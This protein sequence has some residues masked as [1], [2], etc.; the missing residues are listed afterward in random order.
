[1]YITIK[2]KLCNR[3]MLSFLLS[4]IIL[5]VFF[6]IGAKGIYF[7]DQANLSN[8]IQILGQDT[9]LQGIYLPL[10][11]ILGWRYG[12]QLPATPIMKG[13][14]LFHN[15]LMFL[16]I[17]IVILIFVLIFVLI[18]TYTVKL[19]DLPHQRKPALKFSHAALIEILWTLFPTIILMI[20][21]VPS[22]ALLYAIDAATTPKLTLKTVAHQWYWSYEYGDFAI[23]QNQLNPEKTLNW[24]SYIVSDHKILEASK[25]VQKTQLNIPAYQ[26]LL[27]TDNWIDLPSRKH[28]RLIVTSSDVL[29]SS[30][31]LR[32]AA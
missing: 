1:M 5:V 18:K 21:S 24:D 7:P 32:L 27:V 6:F 26:R 13:I 23:L 30:T 10:D 31:D 20:I 29:H 14:I 17:C 12:F 8:L 9:K 15:H 25:V 2:N 11:S 3:P 16:V 4:F 22:F 19:T 28:I